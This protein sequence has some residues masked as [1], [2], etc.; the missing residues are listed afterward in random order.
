MNQIGL[1]H[2]PKR[3][4]NGLT[5]ANREVMKSDDLLK[6]DFQRKLKYIFLKNRNFVQNTHLIPF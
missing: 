3:K 1:S 2:Q 4:P 5:K 6:R